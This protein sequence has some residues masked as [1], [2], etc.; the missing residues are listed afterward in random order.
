M[1]LFYIRIFTRKI[2]TFNWLNLTAAVKY[3]LKSS[4]GIDIIDISLLFE[5][6]IKYVNRFVQSLKNKNIL[7]LR[8]SFMEEVLI[9]MVI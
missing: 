6:L 8:K 4:Q 1:K 5:L 2:G 3:R 9:I 7:E